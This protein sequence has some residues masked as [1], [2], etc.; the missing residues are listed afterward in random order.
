MYWGKSGIMFDI[1]VRYVKKVKN[2]CFS[3]FVISFVKFCLRINKSGKSSQGFAMSAIFVYG[4]DVC[5][6]IHS[7]V[8]GSW[9]EGCAKEQLLFFEE[10][11]YGQKS[12]TVPSSF[13]PILFIWQSSYW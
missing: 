10:I 5:G 12:V 11:Q 13:K 2:H 7:D 6:E 8:N 9:H 1:R 3:V 4:S